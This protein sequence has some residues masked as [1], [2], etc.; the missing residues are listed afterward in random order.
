MAA[1]FP[2]SLPSFFDALPIAQVSFDLPEVS[3]MSR[4]AGGDLMVASLGTRLWQGQVTLGRL[5]RAEARRA[6]TLIDLAQGSEASFMAYQVQYPAPALDP[7]G[8]GLNGF[9][10]RIRQVLA[11]ARLIS[12]KGLPPGY[13]LS[14][15]DMI[16]FSYR[17]EPVR[18]ALHAIVDDG[19]TV[20]GTGQ[21]NSFEVRPHIRPGAA[22][23]A[24]VTLVKPACKA[25]IIPGTVS[26]GQARRFITE[27]MAFEFLQ[28]LR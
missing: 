16:A 10:P 25:R 6:K 26:P 1:V 28:T 22:V 20:L 11:D 21:T 15:G 13:V 18:F 17:T 7:Q 12:L 14:R 24:A 8:G 5:T 4:T 27:G 19:V 2:L 3:E 9:T 23:D